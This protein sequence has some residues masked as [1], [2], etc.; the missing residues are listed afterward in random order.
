MLY[1]ILNLSKY[2]WGEGEISLRTCTQSLWKRFN[3][4][5][6]NQTSWLLTS[7]SLGF[8]AQNQEKDL[9]N[10]KD[11][12]GQST[13]DTSSNDASIRG[14]WNNQPYYCFVPWYSVLSLLLSSCLIQDCHCHRSK[15]CK[16][17]LL[18]S[19]QT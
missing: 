16:P 19:A 8:S 11:K 10:D 12:S 9:E 7:F 5:C 15:I 3:K 1:E 6:S 17:G 4:I 18:S 2:V 13:N 14:F